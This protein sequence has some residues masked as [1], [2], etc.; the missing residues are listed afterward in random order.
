MALNLEA[1]GKKIGP[2]TKDYTWKDA[3][4][5]AL[6][7]GAG[8]SELEYCYEKNL[9]VLPSFSIAAIFEFL[10]HIGINS[11]INLA[12]I[13]HGEQELIFHNPI[14]PEGSLITSG[15]ITHYYDKGKEKGA[16][17]VGESDTFHSG[18]KKLFTSI[19]TIYSR[20]DGGFGGE[21]APK[22]EVVFPRASRLSA[23]NP[24][25]IKKTFSHRT[26]KEKTEY[27]EQSFFVI[28]CLSVKIRFFLS[29]QLCFCV[30]AGMS[31]N[32]SVSFTTTI[33]S[34]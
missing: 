5:Y 30:K 18:G 34:S 11:N 1:L 23:I 4:L 9:K 32:L 2:V 17:V 33:Y 7:V 6:G 25:F 29:H 27:I 10:S 8:F 15:K 20:F 16:L 22:K 21:N 26:D 14:P 12:G 19:I 28:S 3:V 24:P 31:I 13:L